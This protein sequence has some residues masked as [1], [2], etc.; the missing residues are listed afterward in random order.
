MLQNFKYFLQFQV[1]SK[2]CAKTFSKFLKLKCVL[3]KKEKKMRKFSLN[4]SVQNSFQKLSNLL[5]FVIGFPKSYKM[6]KSNDW[7]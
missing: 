6:F 3:K 2:K 4:A 1:R 7:K 5:R